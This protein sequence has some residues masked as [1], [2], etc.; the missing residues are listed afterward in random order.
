MILFRF[1][2]ATPHRWPFGSL[3][4]PLAADRQ[5]PHVA[6]NR[7]PGKIIGIAIFP[8]GRRYISWVWPMWIIGLKLT[9]EQFDRHIRAVIDGEQL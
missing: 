7:Y 9:R 6:L 1:A 4:V 3:S 8:G 5:Y 2:K